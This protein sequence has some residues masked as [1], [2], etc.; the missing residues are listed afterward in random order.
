MPNLS[1]KQKLCDP[2]PYV[3]LISRIP[4]SL[5]NSPG[6]VTHR[7]GFRCFFKASL[8]QRILSDFRSVFPSRWQALGKEMYMV[9]FMRHFVG[10]HWLEI[11]RWVK[12]RKHWLSSRQSFFLKRVLW[13]GV[14]LVS[15]FFPKYWLAQA[16]K[17]AQSRNVA[18]T[19]FP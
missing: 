4:V 18:T 14:I 15:D 13:R 9:E 1:G 17:I 19:S 12:N 16:V 3:K 10:L 2:I 11:W 6:M 7:V 8:R 5:T